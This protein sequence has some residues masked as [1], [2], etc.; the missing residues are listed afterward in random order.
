MTVYARK[1]ATRKHIICGACGNP[2]CRRVRMVGWGG[3]ATEVDG[4][5]VPGRIVEHALV[6]GDGWHVVDDHIELP[7]AA[8]DRLLLGNKPSRRDWT[9]AARLDLTRALR[10]YVPATCPYCGV[11]NQIDPKKLDVDRVAPY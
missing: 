4:R 3:P 7:D 8:L 9:N 11:S 2:L 5:R 10:N 6:W 1:S